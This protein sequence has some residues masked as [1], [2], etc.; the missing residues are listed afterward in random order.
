M[1]LAALSKGKA[2]DSTTGGPRYMVA[3]ALACG[4]KN[5]RPQPRRSLMALVEVCF[6][7][8]MADE[9]VTGGIGAQMPCQ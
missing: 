3:R 5:R 2:A 1:P 6:I 9:I 4:R 7:G 8:L